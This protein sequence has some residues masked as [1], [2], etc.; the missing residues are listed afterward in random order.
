MVNNVVA[1]QNATDVNAG[2]ASMVFTQEQYSQILKMLSKGNS[3]KEAANASSIVT[4]FL[5]NDRND[6]WI[7]D[8]GATNHMA[9]D[10]GMLS[11]ITKQEN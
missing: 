3:T 7:Q 10:N 1:C 2:A 9:A 4:S 11:T 6:K 8:S 5:A